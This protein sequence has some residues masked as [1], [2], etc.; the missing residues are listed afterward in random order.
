M[1]EYVYII[2]RK[3]TILLRIFANKCKIILRNTAFCVIKNKIEIQFMPP[4]P[5]P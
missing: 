1:Y 2:K 5:S 3:H 4:T